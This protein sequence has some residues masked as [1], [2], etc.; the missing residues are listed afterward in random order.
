MATRKTGK[1]Y[2]DGGDMK[3][4]KN[5]IESRKDLEDI[6]KKKV[7]VSMK[8]KND[9]RKSKKKSTSGI[10]IS[11][12]PILFNS[13][14]R[15]VFIEGVLQDIKGYF[16]SKTDGLVAV[17]YEDYDLKNHEF[18]FKLNVEKTSKCTKQMWS[19]TASA[20]ANVVNYMF[21]DDGMKIDVMISTEDSIEG[22]SLGVDLVSNW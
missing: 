16:E 4:S 9:S 5:L 6:P 8:S 18:G 19:E 7:K 21:P 3:L 1:K 11:T 14:M 17:S 2:A 13:K 22:G 20:V 12:E 10:A 15:K